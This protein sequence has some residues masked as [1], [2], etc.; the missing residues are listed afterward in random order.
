MDFYQFIEHWTEIYKPMQH[1]PGKN[2]KNQ[3]FFL[4]DTFM[5]LSD[6]MTNVQ[7]QKS[8]CLIVETNQEGS[9]DVRF[10]TPRYT[11]YFMVRS[12]RMS[13]GQEALDAKLDAKTHMLKFFVYALN[14]QE[15]GISVIKNINLDNIDYQTVGPFYNGWYGVTITLKD[16]VSISRCIDNNDYLD[17]YNFE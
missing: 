9:L 11:L 10:D 3:R 2:S 14:K 16:V 1:I 4:T 15:S 17:D 5:G 8:P 6:F 13:D 7:P 12:D